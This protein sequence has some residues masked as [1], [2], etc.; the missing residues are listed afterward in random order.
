M[1]S[2]DRNDSGVYKVL[3]GLNKLQSP[4]CNKFT[5]SIRRSRFAAKL[6]D[7]PRVALQHTINHAV[8]VDSQTELKR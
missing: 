5:A 4:E 8:T 1:I 7:I 6:V 3:A 2:V